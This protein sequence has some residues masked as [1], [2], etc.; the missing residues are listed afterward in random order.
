[1]PSD[2]SIIYAQHAPALP[3]SGHQRKGSQRAG[4]AHTDT[5][6]ARQSSRLR[7][8]DIRVDI[9]RNTCLCRPK[10][11]RLLYTLAGLDESV[12]H[13]IS[14]FFPA[15]WVGVLRITPFGSFILVA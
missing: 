7:D 14:L 6:V 15:M 3:S 9:Q 10:Q 8:Q 1:M 5:V 11:G 13:H 2:C 4:S 12:P